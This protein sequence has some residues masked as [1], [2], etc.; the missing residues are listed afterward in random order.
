MKKSTLSPLALLAAGLFACGAAQAVEYNSPII[1]ADSQSHVYGEDESEI[2]VNVTSGSDAIYARDGSTITVGGNATEKITIESKASYDAVSA[3]GPGSSV[4]LTAKD[5]I[6]INSTTYGLWGQNNTQ[7][8]QVP[9]NSAAINLTAS[10]IEIHAKKAAVIAYSN[11]RVNLKADK[12]VLTSKDD[13]GNVGTAL[14]VRGYSTVN[15]GNDDGNAV[16]Q[17][18]GDIAFETPGPGNNSG[19]VIDAYV[20]VT[21]SGAD[22]YWNG[23]VSVGYPTYYDDDS[24]T[25][26]NN[27]HASNLRVTLKDGAQ[28]TPR[29]IEVTHGTEGNT[30]LV[31][32]PEDL[33]FLTLSGGVINLVEGAEQTVNIQNLLGT[34]GTINIAAELSED[35]TTVSAGRINVGAV[36]AGSGSSPTLSVNYTGIT[37]DDLTNVKEQMEQLANESVT[38]THGTTTQTHVVEEGNVRGAVTVERDADGNVGQVRVA[39]NTKLTDFSSVNAMSLVQWRNE[40]NHLTR[41]L[42]DLRASSEAIGAWARVYG[43]QSEWG[44][45]NSV[46]MK[47]TAVQVGGDF[48]VSPN[49]LVGGAFS[50]TN[51]DAELATGSAEGDSYTLAT[52]ATYL[53]DN[54]VFVDV[55]GRVGHLKNDVTAG[56]MAVDTSSMAYSLSVESGHQFRFIEDRAYVEPQLE[57]TYG[58][59][60]GDDATASNG[61]YLDQDDYQSLVTR[62]G[63]RAGFDF[64]EKAGTIYAM[65]S[66]SYDF[67]GDADAVASQDGVSENLT[68]SLGG[69]W[70]SYGIG[71]QVKLGDSAFAYGELERTSGGDVVNP[72]LFNCGVRWVF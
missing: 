22:S 44:G 10:S 70:V 11:S 12:I 36:L 2:L 40:I 47:H 29:T 43:G 16:V 27:K 72:Y 23:N 25:D 63:V 45:S 39:R 57:L 56:N 60:S 46:E 14:D 35:N 33:N 48:R 42:G 1:H 13:M 62:V 26:H 9:G 15:I 24:T 17:I 49:W 58:F 28:W 64:P 71:A 5:S 55:I 68:E 66:Y 53:A 19:N 31:S 50:Y 61:V 65:V 18:D 3:V 69:G 59:M 34:G 41:R 54:G 32:K 6:V 7:S 30:P 4:N 67:L 37:A 52:Y 8:A 38:V 51:S 21:L 20:K